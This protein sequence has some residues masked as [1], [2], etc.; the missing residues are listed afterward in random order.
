MDVLYTLGRATAAEIQAQ[1][2]D[3]PSYST[4][5]T[6]LRVLE[7]KGHLTHTEE[8]LR[9]VYLPTVPREEATRSALDR[10]LSTFFNGSAKQAVAT[11]LDPGQYRLSKTELDELAKLVDK[12]RKES[13]S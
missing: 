6:L 8:N 1:L 12:A 4:V 9:Y 3:S 2:A 7:E 5:R 13:Q 11:L 10:L